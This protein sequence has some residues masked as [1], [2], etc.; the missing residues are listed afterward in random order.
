MSAR[1]RAR[2]CTR[3]QHQ[4]HT[5]HNQPPPTRNR[6]CPGLLCARQ[7]PNIFVQND[8]SADKGHPT[9][10]RPTPFAT[11][12]RYSRQRPAQVAW[13]AWARYGRDVTYCQHY[14]G[15]W[16]PRFPRV[17]RRASKCGH[18][19]S[20]P[21][22]TTFGTTM[23]HRVNSTHQNHV[24]IPMRAQYCL[25]TTGQARARKVSKPNEALFL[26]KREGG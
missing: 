12:T 26:Y 5:E 11:H 14:L 22:M 4:H 19:K 7:L 16:A 8:H 20:A 21:E 23:T 10:H 15:P 6:L 3:D 17:L 1:T 9:L 2:T 24:C 18:Q 25:Y 13:G